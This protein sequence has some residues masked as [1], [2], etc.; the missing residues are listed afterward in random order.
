MLSL[1]MLSLG[2]M[3]LA[4]IGCPN[5]H[6]DVPPDEPVQL[7]GDCPYRDYGSTCEVACDLDPDVPFSL[8]VRWSGPYCCT[9]PPG[10]GEPRESFDDCRCEDGTVV[11]PR[12]GIG[13]MRLLPRSTCEFCPGT[14]SGSYRTDTGLGVSDTGPD[15]GPDAPAV[16]ADAPLMTVSLRN[17]ETCEYRDY[18]ST[19]SVACDL[20]PDVPIALG[21]E[22]TGP[23][24]CNFAMPDNRHEGFEDCRCIDGVVLCRWGGSGPRGLPSS[25]CEFCPGTPSGSLRTDSGGPDAGMDAP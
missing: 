11:C 22:W 2:V 7:A 9:F 8:T 3:A 1:G 6:E 15:S 4:L 12:S 25:S 21:V 5:T 17:E 14:P 23:Y 13:S 19:C 10:I 24:C 18:G 20:P 16:D